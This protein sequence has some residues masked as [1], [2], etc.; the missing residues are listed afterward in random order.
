VSRFL[1]PQEAAPLAGVLIE[2]IREKLKSI[3]SQCHQFEACDYGSW[4]Q[5]RCD[6]FVIC[7]DRSSS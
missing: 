3:I 4:I 6:E 1:L 2:E 7:F 5:S